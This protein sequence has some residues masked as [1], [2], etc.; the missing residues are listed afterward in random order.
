MR[1][2]I[3][4]LSAIFVPLA[5]IACGSSDGSGGGGNGGGTGGSPSSSSSSSTSSSSSSSSSS[6]S[7]SSSSSGGGG[8]PAGA[9][10]NAADGA[11]VQSQDVPTIAADC[12]K[13]NITLP[14][15]VKP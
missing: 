15:N 9:C 6:T 3:L 10:T 14:D 8:S 13:A 5:L 7:A 12:G 1:R 2:H 4:T 11:I